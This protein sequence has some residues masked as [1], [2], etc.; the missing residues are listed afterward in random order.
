M[1]RFPGMFKDSFGNTITCIGRVAV[2][3]CGSRFSP[4][5]SDIGGYWIGVRP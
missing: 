1:R 4:T 2:W 3:S 5:D